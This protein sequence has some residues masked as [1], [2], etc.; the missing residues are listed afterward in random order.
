[1]LGYK[2]TVNLSFEEAVRKAREK[3]AENGFGIL[4][5]IDVRKTI[6]EKTGEDFDNYIILGA[7]NPHYAS[8]ALRADRDFGLL[9][10]CN[11]VVYE[12]NGRVVVSAVAPLKLAEQF[13]NEE[14]M[15]VAS[16]VEEKL[17][18]VI[19]SI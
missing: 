15:E 2:K 14:V 7:C 9:M 17:K 13:G 19:D 3:L 5:E 11:V 4:C 8:Q 10:P 6:K 16:T 1:M 12:E 18:K